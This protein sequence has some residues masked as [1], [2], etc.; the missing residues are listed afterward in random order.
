MRT[1]PRLLYLL[2]G[3]L[4]GAAFALVVQWGLPEG[5]PVG[6]P[7]SEAD[8]ASTLIGP[9]IGSQAPDFALLDLQGTERRLRDYRGQVVLVN[10]WATWCGPC[11]LEMPSLQARAERYADEGFVV[12]AVDD[13]E[14][15]DVVRAFGDELGLSIP[16]L[17]DPGGKVQAL[18]RVRGYPS[19]VFIDREGVVRIQHIGFMTD[20]QLDGYIEQ[21]GIG[22]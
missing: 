22:H 12:L 17:L 6:G 21:M 15:E 5:T 19:S 11:R 10:F 7:T 14:P 2:A 20:G 9:D 13:D 4:I 1:R 3:L 16:L 18:Y 8:S